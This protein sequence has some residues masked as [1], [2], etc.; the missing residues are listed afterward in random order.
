MGDRSRSKAAPL[1]AGGWRGGFRSEEVL[2]V[3]VI[4]PPPFLISVLVNTVLIRVLVAKTKQNQ[5]S[6]KLRSERRK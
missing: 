1:K 2:H 6:R 5:R 4:S 3:P